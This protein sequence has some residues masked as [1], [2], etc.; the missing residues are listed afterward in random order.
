MLTKGD[1]DERIFLS[2]DANEEIGTPAK[3]P[4]MKEATSLRERMQAKRN[5][6]QYIEKVGY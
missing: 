5:L 6:P 3:S 1:F 2:D 4:A